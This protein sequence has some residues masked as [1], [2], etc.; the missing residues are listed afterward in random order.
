[1]MATMD[2]SERALTAQIARG[3]VPGLSAAVVAG[4][5]VQPTSA[6]GIADAC[7]GSPLTADHVFLWF[8]MTKIVTAT[9][10]LRL[11]DQHRLALDDEVDALVPGVL[12]ASTT[13][14]RVRHLL[15]HSAGL[16]NPPPIRWV[17]PAS[18]PTP[19]ADAFL[20]ERFARI[21]RLRFEPGTKGAYTNLGFL[22]LGVVIEAA[23]AR[24]FTEYVR[25]EILV[26]LGMQETSFVIGAAPLATGHQRLPHGFGP[27]LELALPRGIVG[28]R[29]RR[30]ITFEPFLVNGAAYGGLVGPVADAA[31]VVLMHANGGALDGTRV[32]SEDA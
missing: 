15:Q 6:S 21:R 5:A 31:R 17:R 32:L 28:P 19:D 12:P 4:G 30:W 16:P 1:M 18:A 2:R 25:D 20:R 14:V 22:L 13:P 7:T 9:A 23:A 11:V 10:A 8:S 3:K 27:L 24:P 26:P 29:A